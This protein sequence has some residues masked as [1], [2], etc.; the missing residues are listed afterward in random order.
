MKGPWDSML[1]WA[2]RISGVW[3]GGGAGAE[4]IDAKALWQERCGIS[5]ELTEVQAAWGPERGRECGLHKGHSGRYW[6]DVQ[7]CG[8]IMSLGL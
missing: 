3:R 7:L 5:E 4:K 6:L 2:W 8:R 1:F